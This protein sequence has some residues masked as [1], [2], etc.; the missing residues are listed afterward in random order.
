MRSITGTSEE[1]RNLEKFVEI[2]KSE[3]PDLVLM[4]EVDG[5]SVRTRTS[6][7]QHYISEKIPDEFKIEFHSKYRGKI[8]P[9]LPLLRHMGNS[10]I[11]RNGE[12][13]NHRIGTGRKCLV[14]EIKMEEL[15]IFSLHLA[16]FFSRL[17]RKQLEEI[18]Q[19]AE[20]REN[21]IL[22]G[23]LNFHKSR[24]EIQD[25][26]EQ[27]GQKVKSPGKTFP[28][29][30]PSQRLDLVTSS[31]GIQIKDLKELGNKFS[32]HRPVKFS[33]EGF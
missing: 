28:A 30:E 3:N 32:D 13:K 8:F 22:A 33:I 14:Q 18:E 27:L 4:Q 5:G 20:Q 15:S 31:E 9:R 25:L 2:L 26:E 23:D 10:V 12:V 6:G 29:A 11:Y 7:Q 19:I 24:K 17:R 16:T 1:K 21:Y